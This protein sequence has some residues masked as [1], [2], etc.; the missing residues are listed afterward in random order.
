MVPKTSQNL[1]HETFG[2]AITWVNSDPTSSITGASMFTPVKGSGQR[3]GLG[4]W[5]GPRRVQC[6]Q[7]CPPS[8]ANPPTSQSPPSPCLVQSLPH[9]P[10]FSA[11]QG[12][13]LAFSSRCLL[14]CQCTWEGCGLPA[15]ATGLLQCKW[16]IGLGQE[17][18]SLVALPP[19]PFCCTLVG[20]FWIL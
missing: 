18:L 15:S 9:P 2:I 8:G 1:F 11:L 3:R 6:H 5:F 12:M 4:E 14:L 16:G 10:C 13:V 20:S 7:S 19:F 17:S